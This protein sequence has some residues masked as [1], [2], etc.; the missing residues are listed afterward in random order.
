[1]RRFLVGIVVITAFLQIP[2]V[3]GAHRLLER[4]GAP[5]AWLV[6]SALG[7]GALALLP[8]RI[9]R[10]RNDAPIATARLLAIEEPYFVHWCATVL[11][12][13]LFIV[14]ALGAGLSSAVGLVARVDVGEIAAAAYVASLA[15]AAFA[16]VVRRRWLR[17]R[18]LDVAVPGLP[19]AFDGYRIAQLSDLHI[20]SYCPRGRAERWVRRAN[21]LAADAVA[22]TGDYVTSGVAFHRTIAS[23]LSGLHARDGVFAVMG[24]HDYF[25]DGEPLASLL[26]EGGVRVLRNERATVERGKDALTIAGID[27]T[28]TRRANIR[29][30]LDGFSFASPL[31]VLAHDPDLFPAL[32]EE[33]A[34]LVLSGHTHWGQIAVPFFAQRWNLS[35]LSTRLTGGIYREGDATLY[36]HPGLGTTGPPVRLG[37][38]PEITVLRLRAA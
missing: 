35:R 25:G 26:R 30:M 36:V 15:V 10:A 16:V 7:L 1:M 12:G 29:T 21:A 38:P 37:S 9:R 22:L 34:S 8:G 17:V 11:A 19:P 6:A 3:L 2:F 4:A 32:A 31:V 33:G 20:G 27:D 13:V 24:N 23:V 28:W 18:E 14:G 5:Y